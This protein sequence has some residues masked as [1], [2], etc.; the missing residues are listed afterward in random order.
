MK[1]ENEALF[2]VKKGEGGSIS[3]SPKTGKF[4]ITAKK[5]K[6]YLTD[7]GVKR[8]PKLILNIPEMGLLH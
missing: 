8:K 5:F 7:D 1:I 2:N 6:Q 3:C 4:I